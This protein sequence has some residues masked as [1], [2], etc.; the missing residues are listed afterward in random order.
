MAFRVVE[1]V[2]DS[3]VTF[4]HQPRAATQGDELLAAALSST[5]SDS[6]VTVRTKKFITNRLL[7]RRQFVRRRPALTSKSQAAALLS[8]DAEASELTSP[9]AAS[10]PAAD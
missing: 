6:A 4:D 3:I 7:Q 1:T 2:T 8:T 10:L 9:C 5:M